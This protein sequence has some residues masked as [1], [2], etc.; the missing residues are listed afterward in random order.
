MASGSITSWQVDGK[1]IESG[2]A[3]GGELEKV[4]N[5]NRIFVLKDTAHGAPCIIFIFAA[6]Y[7]PEVISKQKVKNCYVK[8]MYVLLC[9]EIYMNQ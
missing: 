5:N 4:L 9:E 1:K 2:Q 8:Y 6:F 7:K 3:W